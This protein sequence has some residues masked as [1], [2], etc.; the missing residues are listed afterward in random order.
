MI[1]RGPGFLAVLLYG[2]SPH[3]LPA[4]FPSVLYTGRG[5]LV[6]V[7]FGSFPTP[8][9]PIF[10][11]S[12]KEDQAFSPSYY[13]AP[14]P[15]PPRLSSFTH[16]KRIRLSRRRI[17]WLLPNTLPAHLPSVIY[18]GP[19]FL[20][21]VLYGSS[22]PPPRPSPGM[23]QAVS[24]S[25]SSF[26]SPVELTYGGGRG[27]G[28]GQIIYDDKK[29]WSSIYPSILS[30]QGFT[31]LYNIIPTLNTRQFTPRHSN[32]GFKLIVRGGETVNK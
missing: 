22:P 13:M 11:Q 7:L 25:R 2:S 17:I 23:Q 12:F 19:G 24:H 15:L 30:G 5:F 9:P 1:Y 27:W 4:H 14:P 8:S 32:R 6:V 28:R 29:A 18:R 31:T 20:A 16:L 10:L 21:V 3:P 26:V